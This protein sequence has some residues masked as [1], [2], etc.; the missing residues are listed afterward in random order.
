MIVELVQDRDGSKYW[1]A[2]GK[3][4]GSAVLAEGSTRS[5]AVQ[6]WCQNFIQPPALII[7]EHS[8]ELSKT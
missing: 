8:N 4:H 1:L 2:S 6:Q 5:E 3:K 7:V